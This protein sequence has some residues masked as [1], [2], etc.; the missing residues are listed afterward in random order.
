MHFCTRVA[1]EEASYGGGIK[2]YNTQN[3]C[4]LT[5]TFKERK[6]LYFLRISNF[7]G[8]SHF[9]TQGF[10]IIFFLYFLLNLLPYI[11]QLC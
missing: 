1:K 6:P 10:K 11:Y 2:G 4:R 5:S 9:D 8:V 3:G 7:F